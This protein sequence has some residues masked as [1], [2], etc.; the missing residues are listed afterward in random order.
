[1][2][3]GS[4]ALSRIPLVARP[5]PLTE[6]LEQDTFDDVCIQ[7]SRMRREGTICSGLLVNNCCTVTS[8]T[9]RGLKIYTVVFWLEKEPS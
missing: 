7:F 2:L 9:S 3:T 1:M 4:P 6:S 5:L 8:V